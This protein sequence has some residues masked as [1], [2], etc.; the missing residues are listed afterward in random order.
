VAPSFPLP[1]SGDPGATLAHACLISGDF[2]AAERSGAAHSRLFP[3][4]DPLRPIQIERPY[5]G[6]HFTHA[7]L[8]PC[9]IYQRHPQPLILPGLIF[10]P[11][12][13]DRTVQTSSNPFRPPVRS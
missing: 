13:L 9:P 6:Y 7:C 10:P 2:T 5:R 3:R 12:D 11:S 1:N 4:S 8:T